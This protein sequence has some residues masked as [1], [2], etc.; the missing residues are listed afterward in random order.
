MSSKTT[1]PAVEKPAAT[2]P[3]K[4]VQKARRKTGSILLRLLVVI[5]VV[6]LRLRPTELSWSPSAIWDHLRNHGLHVTPSYKISSPKSYVI[7]ADAE[8]SSAIYTSELDV[9]EV[10]CVRVENGTITSVGSRGMSD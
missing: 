9:K 5:V 3:V 7:C 8:E 1:V 2:P 10:E 4:T 6:W